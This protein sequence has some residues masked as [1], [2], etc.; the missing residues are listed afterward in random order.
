MKSLKSKAQRENKITVQA[1]AMDG[2][3]DSNRSQLWFDHAVIH[4]HGR[5]CVH[6][7]N[8]PAPH[9]PVSKALLAGRLDGSQVWPFV[10]QNAEQ[11]L[12]MNLHRECCAN[13]ILITQV[14]CTGS[15]P[16][17]TKILI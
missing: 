7:I 4:C 8:T 5:T 15:N 17:F 10:D 3:Q 6:L 12:K 11:P 1:H 13:H 14:K 2:W 16:G 9:V